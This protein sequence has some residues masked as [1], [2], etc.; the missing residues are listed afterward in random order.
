[1]VPGHLEGCRDHTPPTA[2]ATGQRQ[3]WEQRAGGCLRGLPTSR[4]RRSALLTAT[5]QSSWPG[6]WGRGRELSRPGMGL[7]RLRF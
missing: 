4:T 3:R 2:D 7:Q 1:M 6:R 5:G